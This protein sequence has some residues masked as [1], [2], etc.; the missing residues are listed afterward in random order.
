LPPQDKALAN[1][2]RELFAM[3]ISCCERFMPG[4][5]KNKIRQYQTVIGGYCLLL[6]DFCYDTRVCSICAAFGEFSMK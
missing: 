5:I 3:V 1:A 4:A 2:K 6:F